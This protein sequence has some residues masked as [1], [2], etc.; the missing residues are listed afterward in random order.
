MIGI[1]KFIRYNS[2]IF[3]ASFLG[4]TSYTLTYCAQQI[5]VAAASFA[6]SSGP[7]DGQAAAAATIR[8]GADSEV[9]AL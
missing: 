2:S 5:V 7:S 8:K 1:I 4:S 9:N 6:G 3:Q